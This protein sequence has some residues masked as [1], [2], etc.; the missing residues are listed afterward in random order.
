MS[1]ADLTPEQSLALGVRGASV[2][3]GAGAG[4]GKTTVLTRRFVDDLAER[5]QGGLVA[6]TFTEKAAR[7]LRGRV[8]AACRARLDEAG[9]DA[10]R[11]RDALRGLEAAPIGTFHAFCGRL[12]RRFPIEAG[13]TPGFSVLEESIA[14]SV[15]DGALARSFRGWL[16]AKD[17]DLIALAVEFGLSAVREALSELIAGRARGDLHMW[18]DREPDEVVALWQERWE[19]EARP[20]LLA[21]LAQSARPCLALMADHP[22]SH[23]VMRERI[24]FLREHLPNLPRSDDAESL[25]DELKAAARV[26]GGGSKAHWPS[27]SVFEGVKKGL[28]DFRASIDK[29]RV[30]LR[31]DEGTT[32]LSAEQGGRLARLA[33]VAIAA[34]DRAKQDAGMLDFDD[35]LVKT[36]DLLR[37]R[38]G[39]LGDAFLGPMPALL[40]DEFQDT[41]PIQGEILRHLAG[42]EFGSGSLFLVG[43]PKQSIYR[44]RGAQPRIFQEFRAD[45][46]E[47]GKRYLTKNF[48]SVP[49][50]LNF[51]NAL[52]AETFPDPA[53]ALRPGPAE[54]PPG[55]GPAVEFLWADE[56][57]ADPSK[58]PTA[59]QRRLAEARWIARHLSRRLDAGWPIRDPDTDEVR[60]A[61]G[62]DV[63]IL[64]RSLT[65]LGPY[66]NALVAEGLDYHV[67]GGSAYFAQQEV[68]DLINL[69]SA[70]E[71][72]CNA[73][74]L[75]GVLRSP[76][77]CLSDDGLY[78]LATAGGDLA[79]NLEQRSRIES[80]PAADRPKLDRAHALLTSWRAL[81]DRL[82]MAA[83][84]D[85]ALD[86]TGYEAALLGEPLGP[87][88]RANVRKL[89]RLA[90]RFDRQGGFT[91]SD[92]VGRLRN[93]LKRPPK[94][95]QAASTEERGT[96]VRLMSIHQAKGLEFPIV[97][98]P[99]LD[100]KPPGERGG[101][102][103]D[104]DLGP[105]VRPTRDDD[106][107]GESPES[108][109][110]LIHRRTEA[111]EE[112]E[113]ALRLFYVA[114]T[115]PRDA[116]IL[117]SGTPP[118]ARPQS[119]AM[120]L[121]ARR[122]DLATGRLA[123]VIP[124]IGPRP[125]SASSDGPPS[126]SKAHAR[127]RKPA[128][129]SRRSWPRS[130]TS[131]PRTW[132]SR[133]GSNPL[134]RACSTSTRRSG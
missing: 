64:F 29:A 28:N 112:A 54:A 9:D 37:D 102:A 118:D 91:L 7:E 71:D 117:S 78:W 114:T 93:D 38:A 83:L 85:R 90:R 11:W 56:P 4:C 45:F 74:A 49:G 1:R 127:R 132:P 22:C 84:L 44:F 110:W 63:A 50:I 18:A 43:D 25:L 92:F 116:L 3:L 53:E 125:R 106:P 57:A 39:D 89:V 62:G 130:R 82:P 86:D 129:V 75:A 2:A 13:V 107:E 60:K 58:K 131:S 33:T 81:K 35:L 121:L 59:H 14:P 42:P 79:R 122:F 32:L 5:P 96:S 34:Y 27:E 12:L 68:I 133:N 61:H 15:R 95:E 111:R 108:L 98:L 77:F 73:L 100:R 104:P 19:R 72:P 88:K 47:G 41:D 31:W 16:A 103:F 51:V 101:V 30:A 40:V 126:R 119:S 94:E 99:D 8:R 115:R 21:D 113:E 76:F 26:Q 55:A 66:E 20:N 10:P 69:L 17:P 123:G 48:R 23:P 24:A 87:R 134:P 109:G 52:F 105:L 46:P 36:R 70:I 80:I 67:V 6:L 124:E 128:R 97:I 120:A 65:D